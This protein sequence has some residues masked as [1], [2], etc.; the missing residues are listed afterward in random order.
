MVAN[1]P[2]AWSAAAELY[3]EPLSGTLTGTYTWQITPKTGGGAAVTSTLA[4][5]FL[6]PVQGLVAGTPPSPTTGQ[7]TNE[8]LSNPGFGFVAGVTF[9]AGNTGNSASLFEFKIT[10]E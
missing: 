2:V 1:L 6:T 3:F 4:S 8:Y 7:I 10:A 5:N 9:S